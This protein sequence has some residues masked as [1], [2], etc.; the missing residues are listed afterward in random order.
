MMHGALS[1]RPPVSTTRFRPSS[2]TGSP[3]RIS[4]AAQSTTAARNVSDEVLRLI[5]KNREWTRNYQVKLA[6][7]TNPKC[8][9]TASMK[10]LNYLQDKDLRTLMRSKDV[11]NAIS[12]HARRILMKKGKL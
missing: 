3:V 8:P 7:A 6:L 12:S 9:L 1:S 5:A 2:S 11:P 10:F 4:I